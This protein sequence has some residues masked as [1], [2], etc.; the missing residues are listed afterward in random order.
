M[1]TLVITLTLLSSAGGAQPLS[2]EETVRRGV[3]RNLSL[4]SERSAL[5]REAA[6]Q[7]GAWTA[8]SPTLELRAGV[9]R[10]RPFPGT[11]ILPLTAFAY[12]A[13]VSWRSPVGTVV[14]A[15]ATMAHPLHAPGEPL[16]GGVTLGVAQPLLKDAWL[17]GAALPL[18]EAELQSAIQRELFREAINTTILETETAYWDLAVA[19]AEVEIKTRSRGRAQRQFEDTSE[20][21]RR[22]ILA[23]VEIYVPHENVVF[24]EQELLVAQQNLVFARRRL[25]ELLALDPGVELSPSQELPRPEAVLPTVEE[26]LQMGLS[27]NPRL[28]AQRGRQTLAEVRAGFANNQALPR[29]DLAASL[30]VQSL[31]SSWTGIWAQLPEDPTPRAQTGLV[32]ALPLD[33]GA[34]D[35]TVRA[36]TLEAQRQAELLAREEQRVRFELSDQLTFLQTQ[37]SVLSLAEKQLELADLKLQAENEKY[38]SGLSPLVDVIRFQRDLDLASIQLRRVLRAVH[39]GRA[40]LLATQG[41][42]HE[43]FDLR[44]Q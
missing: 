28:V 36:A 38:K 37:L 17:T 3:E 34:I 35:A 24:F 6:N 18:R 12:S 42:L 31:A 41:T 7:R 26:V 20:N 23:G 13:G 25:A 19:A 39:V 5:G 14:T 21:I 10:E 43:R 8:F 32:F 9:A 44:V 4:M 2:L 30:S 16:L 22:G 33:R 15:D 27:K 29:L 1:R 11:P 40:R